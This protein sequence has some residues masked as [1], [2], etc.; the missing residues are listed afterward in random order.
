MSTDGFTLWRQSEM[1]KFFVKFGLQRTYAWLYQRNI[2][3]SWITNFKF[4]L[5]MGS[6]FYHKLNKRHYFI[7]NSAGEKV[8]ERKSIPGRLRLHFFFLPAYP[9]FIKKIWEEGM[10]RTKGIRVDFYPMTEDRTELPF[11]LFFIIK[12]FT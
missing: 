1:M 4:S 12:I 2:P 9:L 10:F 11:A 8:F 6:L 3:D 7:S 5:V